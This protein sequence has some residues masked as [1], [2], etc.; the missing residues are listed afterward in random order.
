MASD[1][2][3]LV[4]AVS[5]D[6]YCDPEVRKEV[7]KIV[8]E[9]GYLKAAEVAKPFKT[10]ILFNYDEVR[11]DPMEKW[12]LQSPTE[13]HTIIYDSLSSQLEPVY[14][15]ILDFMNGLFK[16][17]EKVIDNF[18]SSTGSSHFSEMGQR[19]DLMR[20]EAMNMMGGMVQIIKTILNL[21]YDLKEMKLILKTYEDRRSKNSNISTSAELSLKQRWMDVVD[22][23][24][25]GSS[26]LKHLVAQMD[27]VLIIDAF[28]AVN[29][30]EDV[31][32]LDVNERVRKILYQRVKDYQDW[33]TESEK[34]LKVRYQIEIKYL[35]NQVNSVKLYS[36]W[37]KPYLKSMSQLER[38]ANPTAALVTAF[39]TTLLELTLIGKS[40]YKP[41]DDVK[42][43]ILPKVFE[44]VK[45]RKYLPIV[46]VE[47][48][49]RGVPQKV[50]QGYSYGGRTEMTFTSYALNED[51]LKVLKEEIEK[52]DL[53]DLMELIEGTTTESLE[54]LQEDIDEFLKEAGEK[55]Q[56]K[57]EKKERREQDVNPFTALFEFLIPAKK[58][59]KEEAD[60]SKGI[61]P[62]NSYEK[63]IRSQ[64]IV[65][66]RKKCFTV[67]DVYKKA[68]S[69]QSYES[70]YEPI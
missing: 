52:D 48:K 11:R 26:S 69:M 38:R 10:S 8:K 43:D 59:K 35:R 19:A 23:Q 32:K 33:L 18:T 54:A 3:N 66:A 28:M 14:F 39:N 21:V 5:P 4:A 56:K 42:E 1:I 49:F 29:N 13:Q 62:D 12:G 7:K 36:R 44:R 9:E 37:L 47:F 55:E 53:G 31:K 25:R 67:F 45:V 40:E 50:G 24:K 57:R 60:L 30:L 64:A 58:E 65:S 22:F 20:K 70:P 41:E 46:I 27:Y 51:E 61:K 6:V 16:D 68:H 2:H 63:I 17:V 34:Q 15:W